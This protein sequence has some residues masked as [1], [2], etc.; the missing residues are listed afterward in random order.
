MF[1]YYGSKSKIIDLY[2]PPQYDTIIEPFAGSARYALKYWDRNII[3]VDKY[4]VVVK[5]WKWLQ[6]CSEKDIISLPTLRQSDDIRLLSLCEEAKMLLGFLAGVSSTQPRYKVSKFAAN[7]DG[8]KNE[9]K[10][11]A[12]NIHKIKNWDIRHGD[13]EDIENINSTWFIDPPYQFGGNAYVHKNI[14]YTN[15]KEW[16]LSRNGHIIICE[17]TK[18]DWLEFRPIKNIYG[19]NGY[20]EI[21]TEAIWTNRQSSYGVIQ[22][23]LFSHCG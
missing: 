4:E 6:L 13:Y 19:A 5:V 21:T 11:I 9:L 7:A 22:G 15:L 10:R 3:I 20:K 12:A 2:P 1:S 18:A 16:C 8:R 14:D 17:N 23:S